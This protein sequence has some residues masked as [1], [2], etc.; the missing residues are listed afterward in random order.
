MKRGFAHAHDEITR[1][2]E[3]GRRIGLFGL[4]ADCLSRDYDHDVAEFL[5]FEGYE[6]VPIGPVHNRVLPLKTYPRLGSV[7]GGVDMAA[8]F[9]GTVDVKR[10][11]EQAL[12]ADVSLFWFQK[13]S[14]CPTPALRLARMG[15]KVVYNRCLRSEYL[16]RWIPVASIHIPQLEEVGGP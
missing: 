3:R 14:R 5:H 7:P 2:L 13:G 4:G 16:A 9:P 11:I 15:K 6:I 1:I 12:R 10:A 8:V